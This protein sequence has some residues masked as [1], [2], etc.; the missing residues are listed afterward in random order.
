MEHR[1][2]GEPA[3]HIGR[4]HG[5][6]VAGHGGGDEAAAHMRQSVDDQSAAL[7]GGH[8]AGIGGQ[9][10]GFH[11]VNIRHAGQLVDLGHQ[12]HRHQLIG[13][14]QQIREAR[15]DLAH[16]HL[17]EQDH[18]L[19]QLGAV[20]V[21]LVALGQEHQV[22]GHIAE[23]IVDQQVAHLQ[24]VAPLAHG[25]LVHE[26]DA[27]HIGD[28]PPVVERHVQGR[29]QVL[30]EGAQQHTPHPQPFLEIIGGVGHAAPLAAH[31]DHVAL[32]VQ[33]AQVLFT[34]F[35]QVQPF[36][37]GHGGDGPGLADHPADIV[38]DVGLLL[39]GEGLPVGLLQHIPDDAAHFLQVPALCLPV[40]VVL[41]PEELG[42]GEFH[43]C[44]YLV[45]P[46][47][48]MRLISRDSTKAW[49]RVRSWPEL[50]LLYR[51]SMDSTGQLYS[52]CMI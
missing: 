36:G 52:S 15:H 44:H 24:G 30:G 12:E 47:F 33:G 19:V 11:R 50:P 16:G 31:G 7:G 23:D 34:G 42:V 6:P 2:V 37:G 46:F 45:P 25:V 29:D 41:G 39:G 26:A 4:G 17:V 5:G 22:L 35:Q 8:G 48:W 9:A 13:D 27:A 14:A 10:E 51:R 49:T 21:L 28:H 32:A 18:L 40:H 3:G 20:A 43:L 38:L 1:Q